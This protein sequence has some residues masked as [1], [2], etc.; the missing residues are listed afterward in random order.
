MRAEIDIVS[1][2]EE[3]LARKHEVDDFPE[4]FL[5]PREGRVVEEAGNV[6]RVEGSAMLGWSMPFCVFSLLL[7]LASS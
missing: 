1:F 2:L 5:S 6:E 3:D 7:P 4:Y